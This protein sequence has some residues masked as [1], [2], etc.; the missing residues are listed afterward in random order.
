LLQKVYSLD[1]TSSHSIN[2][3]IKDWDCKGE[4]GVGVLGAVKTGTCNNGRYWV[5]ECVENTAEELDFTFTKGIWV[6][7]GER[8]DEDIA[9]AYDHSNDSD[10]GSFLIEF[11]ILAAIVI[12]AG[13][14]LHICHSCT[15]SPKRLPESVHTFTPGELYGSSKLG[16][17]QRVVEI[18]AKSGHDSFISLPGY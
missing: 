7:R 3:D 5:K 13:I 11:L 16:S 14:A 9:V 18:Q 4:A 6:D 10:T 1:T 8:C 2:F 15:A 17:D 12:F